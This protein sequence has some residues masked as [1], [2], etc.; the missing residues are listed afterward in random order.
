MSFADVE[1]S[2]LDYGKKAKEGG[3]ALEDMT[4][5][6]QN[7]KIVFFV[8]CL[9]VYLFVCLFIVCLFVYLFVCLF[10]GLFVGLFVCLGYLD[11]FF[12]EKNFFF[13]L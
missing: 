2:I 7:S 10:V 3:L 6:L 11:I 8:W 5:G 12:F 13:T 9:F 1:K 4:G